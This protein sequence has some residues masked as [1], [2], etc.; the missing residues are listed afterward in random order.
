MVSQLKVN[1]IIKQSGSSITIGEAGDTVSGP[2][3]NVPA[4]RAGLTSDQGNIANN[5][6]TVIQINSK[7]FDTGVCYNNTGSTV[8]LN[9][10]STPAYSFAPN[11]AGKYFFQ[12]QTRC[13]DDANWDDNQISILKNG[14][15]ELVKF[16]F[17]QNYYNTGTC[18]VIVEMNGTSDYVTGYFKHVRGGT[19]GISGNSDKSFTYFMGY[20][21]IGA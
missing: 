20:R 8:T 6:L 16:N 2:F 1:E 18:S 17:D 13:S 11:I 10:I 4:F 21:M 7:D 9:G 15:T 3:T 12:C 19:I 14:S 5:T